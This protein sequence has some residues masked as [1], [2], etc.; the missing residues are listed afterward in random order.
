M[1]LAAN[2]LN[3]LGG[4]PMISQ[5]AFV[6]AYPSALPGGVEGHLEIHLRPFST[7]QLTA[8]IEI[9]EPRHPVDDQALV[10]EVGD[11]DCTIGEFY[12]TIADAIGHLGADAFA[13]APRHQVGPDLVWGSVT[14]TDAAS[15]RV[16]LDTI[17]EQGEGTGTS[18]VEIDGPGGR[19][20][21][22]HY[23][24][25]ME[26]LEGRRLVPDRAAPHGFAYQGERVD[27]NFDGVV[28]LPVDPRSADYPR[29]S[30]RQELNDA[31][32]DTYTRLLAT[33][34]LLTN[35]G[36]DGSTFGESLGLMRLLERQAREITDHVLATG[37]PV[38]PSFEYRTG[39]ASR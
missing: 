14:V 4:R 25:F 36:A 15:A 32:N 26:I 35:G 17:I 18:P 5:P 11:G 9:E 38:G 8:F 33:L 6:P 37:E 1:V 21:F 30:A 13:S 20:D 19:N 7:E 3:A 16:A 2:V 39:G 23:Y 12:M 28:N 34:H 27:V 31:F 22:A 10:G 29:G 24:R